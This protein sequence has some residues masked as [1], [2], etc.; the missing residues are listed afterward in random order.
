M[1]S[2]ASSPAS[3][4]P[5]KECSRR[6]TSKTR[7]AEPRSRSLSRGPPESRR[8]L[9]QGPATAEMQSPEHSHFQSEDSGEFQA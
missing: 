9:S 5:P 3:E 2:W 6:C 1:I 4:A 7:E 8:S